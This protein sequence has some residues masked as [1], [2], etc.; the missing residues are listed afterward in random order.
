MFQQ[1]QIPEETGPASNAIS[2]YQLQ[3][4]SIKE[5]IEANKK[6]LEENREKYAGF[7]LACDEL[8]DNRRFQGRGPSPFRDDRPGICCGRLGPG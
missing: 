4:I 2:S 7:L 5:Q 1:V 3:T 6:K 8:P